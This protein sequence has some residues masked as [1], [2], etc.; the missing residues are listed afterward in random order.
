ML[1]F[2]LVIIH[3]NSISVQSLL[4]QQQHFLEICI[5]GN[6]FLYHQ[7]RKMIGASIAVACGS[8]SEAYFESCLYDSSYF[9]SSI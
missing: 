8:W 6:S 2:I 4:F 1:V 7:I 3:S 5:D 9:I